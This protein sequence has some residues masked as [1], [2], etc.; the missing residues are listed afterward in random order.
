K[1]SHAFLSHEYC[2]L[3]A[4]VKS[5]NGKRPGLCVRMARFGVPFT[6]T[7]RRTQ[8]W[9]G[10]LNDQQSHHPPTHLDGPNGSHLSDQEPTGVVVNHLDERVESSLFLAAQPTVIRLYLLV[11]YITKPGNQNGSSP[12]NQSSVG[13]W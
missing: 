7:G 8:R 1:N 11:L 13:L 2:L 3:V 4:A 5:K 10:Y 9:D 12:L 6:D